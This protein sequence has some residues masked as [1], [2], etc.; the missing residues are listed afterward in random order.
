[1]QKIRT[2]VRIAGKEYTIAS[3]DSEAYVNRVASWVD[4]RMSELAA[5]TRL[6]ATQLAVLTAVNAADDMMKSR[7]EIRRL[8]AELEDLRAKMAAQPEE[9]AEPAPETEA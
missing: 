6:P 3:T 7:D 2:T 8:E 5:A 9:A 1:M 4:R